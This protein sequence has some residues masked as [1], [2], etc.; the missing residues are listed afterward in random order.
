MQGFCSQLV[1][2]DCFRRLGHKFR[3]RSRQER[4]ALA[5]AAADIAIVPYTDDGY[6]FFYV[7]VIAFSISIA[8]AYALWKKD[9]F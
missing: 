3:D 7:M 8:G 4:E 9:M 1:L 6:G 5:Q 2:S